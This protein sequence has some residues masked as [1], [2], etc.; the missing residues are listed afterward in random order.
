MGVLGEMEG[1]PRV[2]KLMGAW[3][4]LGQGHSESILEKT[5]HTAETPEDARTEQSGPE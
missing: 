3:P 1:I 2:R 5:Q 4:Q